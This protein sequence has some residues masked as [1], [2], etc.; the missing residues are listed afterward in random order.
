[1]I[2]LAVSLPW[3]DS[4]DSVKTVH[5][6]LEAASIVF[7]ALLVA[8]DSAAHLLEKKSPDRARVVAGIGLIF[9]WLAVGAEIVGYEYGQRNDR[10][11]GDEITS[12]DAIAK[13]AKVNADAAKTK[14]GEA[15]SD[16][17]AAKLLAT[18]AR[19]EADS[20]EKK[21]ALA[22]KTATEAES[23]LA[24]AVKSADVLTAKLDRITT[25]RSLPHSPQI[26]ALLRPFRGTEYMFTGVC[27]DTECV[28][29]LRDID[30]VLGDAGWKRIKA[31]HR[32]PG[33]VLWGNKADDDGAGFDFEPGIKVSIESQIP[34]IEQ[35]QLTDLPQYIRAA[36]VLNTMLASNVSPPENT[37]VLVDTKDG[38]S[39]VISIAVGRK[40]L[41]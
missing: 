38:T 26:I 32:F 17:G 40:P 11:A 36:V 33:L 16:A 34:K 27:E 29:L 41:P 13:E 19:T 20:F 12:L 30:S 14:S 4:L 5:S 15:K 37:G 31:P 1:M 35:L 22:N 8:F 6:D 9:F 28:K 21:I 39:T 18:G 2:N 7:F 3:W 24:E 10:L 23:H 25:P